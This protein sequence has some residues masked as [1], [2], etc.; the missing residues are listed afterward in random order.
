MTDAEEDTAHDA[1]VAAAEHACR[2]MSG[3]DLALEVCRLRRERDALR[4]ELERLTGA[5]FSA[6]GIAC[7]GRR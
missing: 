3:T 4:D 7:S 6:E 1:E 2:H 5:V